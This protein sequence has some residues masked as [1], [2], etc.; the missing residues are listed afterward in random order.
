MTLKR[1]VL[2]LAAALV[3]VG[4]LAGGAAA[5]TGKAPVLDRV[6]LTPWMS[7]PVVTCAVDADRT[8]LT[9]NFSLGGYSTLPYGSFSASAGGTATFA[10]VGGYG[11]LSA[12]QAS[13]TLPA[14]IGTA[15]GSIAAGSTTKGNGSCDPATGA[16]E[17]EIRGAVYSAQLPDGTAD[18][19]VVDLLLST[20]GGGSTFNVAFDS[21]RSP[22]ID[23][24][25]DGVWDGDDNCETAPNSDQ[26][27]VDGDFIGDVCDTYDNRP[28]LTLLGEL[29]ADTKGVKNGSKLVA[30]VDHAITALQ[31]GQVSVAC[32]DLASYISQVQ[33]ARGK[34]IPAATADVLLA[35][36]RHIRTVLGC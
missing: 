19:G 32:T 7:S 5:A 16:A 14:G 22:E 9:V 23:T 34:S 36:A 27:D 21:R 18:S 3:A 2:A 33:S 31:A 35:K 15:S 4:T 28:A 17:I 11:T 10:L 8:A 20:A 24:D 12:L 6:Q 1:H 26:R 29:W 30:K 13:F 25:R